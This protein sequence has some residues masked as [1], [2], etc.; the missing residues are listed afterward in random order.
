MRDD[1]LVDRKLAAVPWA[2]FDN[3]EAAVSWN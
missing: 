1:V 3:D 2:T